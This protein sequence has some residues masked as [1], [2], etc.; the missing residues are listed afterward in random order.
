MMD[1]QPMTPDEEARRA[2]AALWAE[3]NASQGL[4]M[5]LVDIGPGRAVIAMTVTDAMTNGHGTC[6]GGYIFTLADS[7]FAFACN[8]RRQRSVAQ[9]C[10]ITYIAP[11]RQGMRLLAE[12]VERQ[13]AERSGITDV[14]VRDEAGAVIA[15]FR[16]HS[17]TVP[18]TL[19]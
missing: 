9:Q 16:G 18:G 3:D 10:Q 17:R 4:G 2:A 13:R 1:E 7:A 12:G 6:H 14:T 11:A 19:F 8:S 15:E 5:E